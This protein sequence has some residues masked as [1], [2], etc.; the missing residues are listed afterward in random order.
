MKNEIRIGKE[1]QG[2]SFRRVQ[3]TLLN[4]AI[5]H[6][7]N[8]LFLLFGFGEAAVEEGCGFGVVL[9]EDFVLIGSGGG[10]W[11]FVVVV[12]R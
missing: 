7:L 5:G 12:G 2:E 6:N 4:A 3:K 1:K 10:L 11:G 8:L 9:T